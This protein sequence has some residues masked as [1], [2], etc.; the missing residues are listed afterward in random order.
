M[1]SGTDYKTIA[2]G[3]KKNVGTA[4]HILLVYMYVRHCLPAHC[5]QWKATPSLTV[6]KGN[7]PFPAVNRY[8]L[9]VRHVTSEQL[10]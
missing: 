10:F 4:V 7:N 9:L 5:G 1:Q 8:G 2:I 3:K 6:G